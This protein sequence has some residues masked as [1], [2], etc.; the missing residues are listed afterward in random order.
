MP[1]LSNENDEPDVL[2]VGA[3]FSG[4][5]LLYRLRKLGFSVQVFEAAPGFGG[6]W[7]WNAYPGARVDAE[8]PHYALSIPELWDDW[9][10]KERF[11]GREELR[12]Y[13]EYMDQ[14]L[15][16]KKDIFFNTRVVAAHFDVDISRWIVKTEGG[17]VV[18]PR[19]FIPCVGFASKPYAPDF[20]GLDTFKGIC[21][22]TSK[23]P[24][25]GV[26][27][28]NK[29]VG[30]IGTGATAVQVIQE[31]GPE[32]SHLTVF[33]RTPNLALPMQQRKLDPEQETRRKILYPLIFRR[34]FQTPT[35]FDVEFKPKTLFAA[36]PEERLLHWEDAWSRGGFA[37]L[38]NNYQDLLLDE[39]A[40]REAYNFWRD[41]VR[42]RLHDPRI[43]EKLAPTVAVHP[44][45]TKRPSL[46]QAYYEV[47]NQPNVTLVDLNESGISEITSKGLLT[48]D[49]VEH[50][51]DV[52]ILATGFDSMTGSL[53]QM[54]IR[55]ID[56]ISLAEKWASGVYTNLG[57]TCA[58]FPNM[59]FPYGVQAPTAFTNGPSC[60]EAQAN[61]I[62]QCIESMKENNLTAICA[63]PEAAADWR[64]QVMYLGSLTL[65]GKA[66]SW[67]MGSNI[68]G[69]P[70]EH[71]N[72]T[73]GL[74]TYVNTIT[75]V[76]ERGY[77]GFRLFKAGEKVSQDA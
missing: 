58:Y 65:Y 16:L 73:G 35:G 66:K 50:E 10:W 20:K 21:H 68:P 37:F 76:A 63:T 41:K 8:I 47:F 60:I 43:Q 39:D 19:F 2:V 69:K 34:Q 23:W 64:A 77:E 1:L 31:I 4:V 33:Q 61:W 24:Q 54:D 46:E 27:L 15:D 42:A 52:L 44:L 36:T 13:F 11:P 14:K 18:R 62:V 72:Y 53:T 29:R 9:T 57:M 5:L 7:Y 40:N 49:A 3:G 38:L 51:F 71:L 30:I 28:R 67:Y 25:Q 59:F 12:E 75:R 70:I 32:V 22:H 6:V 55:G 48:D 26:D 74:H 45:G 17:H 56:G